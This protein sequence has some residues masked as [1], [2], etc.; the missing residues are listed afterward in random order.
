MR[1]GELLKRQYEPPQD[2]PHQL[3]TLLMQVTSQQE[4]D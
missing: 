3:F 4:R 2:L 1:I